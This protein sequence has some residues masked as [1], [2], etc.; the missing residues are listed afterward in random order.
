MKFRKWW[1]YGSL[2]LGGV[3]FVA[4]NLQKK[5]KLRWHRILV[6]V[7]ISIILMGGYSF[8][9]VT[10]KA[11]STLLTNVDSCGV[12]FG[13]AVWRDSQPSWALD[14]RIQAA[15]KLYQTGRINC[16]ILSGGK[17]K[18]G[19]H[20]VD[21]MQ[22]ITQKFNIP[23][24]NITLDYNGENTLATI[25]NLPPDQNQFV[26]ISNDFHLARIDLIARKKGLKN[27]YLHAAPYQK[28]RY[29]K[30]NQYFLREIA[31]YLLLRWGL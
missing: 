21:V 18:F 2:A 13:A 15:I 5:P 11:N 16:L 22:N 4:K 25:A 9:Q 20:E 23:V 28:G 3:G 14:D 29:T 19:E 7:I 31:G 10:S 1:L 12:V 26:F 27:F 8:N 17:S 24:T 30:N 6:G